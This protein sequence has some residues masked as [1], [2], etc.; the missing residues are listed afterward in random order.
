LAALSSG[1]SGSPSLLNWLFFLF[2]LGVRRH[3]W[4]SWSA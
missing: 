2:Y 3:T 4:K 1:A